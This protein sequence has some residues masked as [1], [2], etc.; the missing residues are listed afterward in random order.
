MVLQGQSVRPAR[1]SAA[2]TVHFGPQQ[3][4]RSNLNHRALPALLP[5]SQ[6]GL[7]LFC[8]E[9]QGNLTKFAPLLP[10]WKSQHIFRCGRVEGIFLMDFHFRA[11]VS[12]DN[13]MQNAFILI[14][15]KFMC[16]RIMCKFLLVLTKVM[17]GSPR[18]YT[19]HFKHLNATH[20]S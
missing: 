12:T 15:S 6:S 20:S 16:I 4:L 2:C 14:I 18:V 10:A 11:T 19:K 9:E 17:A 8:F 3:K 1:R 7:V 5:N 13:N